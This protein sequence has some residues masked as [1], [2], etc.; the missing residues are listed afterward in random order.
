[1]P[2]TLK[3]IDFSAFCNCTSLTSLTIPQNVISI[4]MSSL[5]IGSSTNKA[6]ITMLP[7]TPPHVQDTSFIIGSYI[8]QIIVPAGTGDTY[9]AATNWSNY[10][11][12][13][14]EATE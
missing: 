9:K 6:T 5:K 8:N 12:L 10:A 11:D 1:M 13:I 4:G 7:M 2:N 14:V 3:N